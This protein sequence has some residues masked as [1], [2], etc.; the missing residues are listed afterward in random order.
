[1]IGRMRTLLTRAKMHGLLP[2]TATELFQYQG[3][4]FYPD[5]DPD[6]YYEKKEEIL[7]KY[8]VTPEQWDNPP[9]SWKS[10]EDA[11]NCWKEMYRLDRTYGVYETLWSYNVFT[12]NLSNFI[13]RSPE[14]FT[15]WKEL[16]TI[17]YTVNDKYVGYDEE[18]GHTFQRGPERRMRKEIWVYDV[19]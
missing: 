11:N 19:I 16:R 5:P 1:M 2:A 18:R 7:A 13:R 9:I 8:G 4:L 10:Y 15:R 14:G 6:K 3:K 12:D 17:K